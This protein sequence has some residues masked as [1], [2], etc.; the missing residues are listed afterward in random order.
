MSY[1][2][3]GATRRLVRTFAVLLEFQMRLCQLSTSTT[4]FHVT[5]GQVMATIVR[6][7]RTTIDGASLTRVEKR[8][9]V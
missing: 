7:I 3:L 4:L 2:A 5:D 9:M 8:V 1:G 6:A